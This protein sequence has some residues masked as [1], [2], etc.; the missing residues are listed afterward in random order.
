MAKTLKIKRWEKYAKIKNE[1]GKFYKNVDFLYDDDAWYDINTE[2]KNHLGKTRK[3]KVLAAGFGGND[4]EGYAVIEY[5][6][7]RPK[8]PNMKFSVKGKKYT[9]VF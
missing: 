2:L 9:M 7:R 6:G 1:S 5:S 8:I 4:S 3:F